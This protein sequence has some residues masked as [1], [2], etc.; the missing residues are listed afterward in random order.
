M[1]KKEKKGCRNTH[2][3]VK[4]VTHINLKRQNPH[5]TIT[6][7]RKQTWVLPLFQNKICF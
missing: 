6:D 4:E 3:Q 5:I 1:K 2:M 7:R